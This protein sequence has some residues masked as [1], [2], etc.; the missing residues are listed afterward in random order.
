[1]ATSTPKATRAATTHDTRWIFSDDFDDDDDVGTNR[2][3]MA[4]I[5][6]NS[7][8]KHEWYDKLSNAVNPIWRR[9]WERSD[10]KVVADGGANRVKEVE[11]LMKKEDEER[12]GAGGGASTGGHEAGEKCFSSAASA[13]LQ[14]KPHAIIGDLDSVTPAVLEHYKA[15]GVE[16]VKDADVDRNDL[17]KCLNYV[18]EFE[19]LQELDVESSSSSSSTSLSPHG[20]SGCKHHFDAVVIYG[21]LGGRFDQSMASVHALFKVSDIFI[22]LACTSSKYD[23]SSLLPRKNT[24]VN[25]PPR[26]DYDY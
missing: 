1:M 25:N 4:L 11:D 7:P 19:R 10:L 12:G 14:H 5:V 22:F 17:E 16:V 21:G 13:I 26:C 23:V 20:S 6:L 3:R 9:V 24:D 18:K 15:E 2:K 8:D